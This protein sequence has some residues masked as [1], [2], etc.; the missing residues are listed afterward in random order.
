MEMRMI[1][2][3]REECGISVY[4]GIMI[5]QTICKMRVTP[6][7]R[8]VVGHDRLQ[9]EIRDRKVE[10]ELVSG[11]Y[12]LKYIIEI[13]SGKVFKQELVMRDESGIKECLGINHMFGG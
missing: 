9:S 10:V 12:K 1:E 2:N 3:D 7:A 13:E 4:K 11:N 6:V 8:K 5:W